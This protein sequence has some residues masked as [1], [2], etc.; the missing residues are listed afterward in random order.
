MST[1]TISPPSSLKDQSLDSFSHDLTGRLRF[2]NLETETVIHET[3]N[4][5]STSTSDV[6]SSLQHVNQV[7]KRELI[8]PLHQTFK[9]MSKASSKCKF[10]CSNLAQ[11]TLPKDVTPIMPLKIIN[12]P[13]DL[14]NK[15]S[16]I[17]HDCGWQLTLTL[18][19]HHQG[20][21]AKFKQLAEETITNGN[22]IDFPEYITEVPDTPVRIENAI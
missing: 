17:L 2:V 10:L 19:N 16:N 6:V 13:S 4:A 1:E 21:I 15:W 5:S 12:A 14:E 22:Q 20:Q 3:K 11:D 8:D 18:I 7:I 9:N